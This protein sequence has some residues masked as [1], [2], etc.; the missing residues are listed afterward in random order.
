MDTERERAVR[1]LAYDL[2]ERAG[3]PE[4]GAEGYWYEAER[5]LHEEEHGLREAAAPFEPES[6]A[7]APLSAAPAKP[8]RRPAPAR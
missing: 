2:W 3:R 5:Q 8:A 4:G 1:E 6:E 7:A